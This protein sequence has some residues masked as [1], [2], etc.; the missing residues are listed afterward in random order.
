MKQNKKIL[1]TYNA[2]VSIYSI[3]TGKP[4]TID[5]DKKD[6]S[7][8]GFAAEIKYIKSSLSNY[9]DVVE[10]LAVTK[11][12]ESTI[13]KIDE[14]EPDVIYNFVESIEGIASYEYCIA[15]IYELLGYEYT[16]NTPQTLGNCLNKSITKNILRA[17][18][19]NTPKSI[20]ISNTNDLKDG[21]FPIEFPVIIKLLKEDASIGIS[22][23]SVVN[24]FKMLNKQ[25][26]FLFNTYK[27]EII[28][29]EYIEGRELNVAVLGNTLLPISEIS[30]KG[31]PKDLPKIVTYE[32]KWIDDSVYY[33]NT[34]SICP[35]KL[36]GQLMKLVEDV[37]IKAIN[38]L[39]CRDYARVDI[40]LSNDNI[41]YVIE[42][43]P[44]PDI[45]V[46][47][48]FSRAA[49]Y[50]GLTHG[51]LLYKISEFALNRSI[52]DTQDKAV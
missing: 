43:N 7:E 47:S 34:K 15:G 4:G 28:I 13:Y 20:I 5:T 48:G 29:E 44:N 12:I 49:K 6:L 2:P 35:A 9:Y 37:A 25:I 3:Y 16:G 30:F 26:E 33:N 40:R 14:F 8:K 38:A 36:N 19:I 23:F 42:I 46:D 32:S 51:Q 1:I 50:H 17:F 18:N 39:N 31:L 45:S 27:S 52:N 41:L 24:N 11:N 22:E 10:T 21:E